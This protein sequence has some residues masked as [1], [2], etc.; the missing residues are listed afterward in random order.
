MRLRRRMWLPALGALLG[1][2]AISVPAIAGPT[3]PQ[4][5]PRIAPQLGLLGALGTANTPNPG[6]GGYLMRQVGS[7]SVVAKFEMPKLICTSQ[8]TGIGPGAF[9]IA[10][11]SDRHLFDFA[12]IILGCTDG[13]PDNTEAVVVNNVEYDFSHPIYPGDELMVQL[14]INPNQSV[15]QVSDLTGGNT[16]VLS[17]AG[18]GSSASLE[19]VG[20]DAALDASTNAQLPIPNFGTIPFT[21]VSV[22]GNPLGLLSPTAYNMQTS[23]KVLQVTTGPFTGTGNDAFSSVFKHS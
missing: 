2:A 7:T 3:A 19:L 21:S 5:A 18:H 10:G 11:P 16:F 14:T 1:V 23:A 9:V 20:E 6:F 17:K 22:G 13:Q 8:F 12:G 4:H 15:I